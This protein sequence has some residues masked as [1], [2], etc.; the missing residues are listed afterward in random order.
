MTQRNSVPASSAPDTTP[1]GSLAQSPARVAVLADA[2]AA[3][4]LRDAWIAGPAQDEVRVR[5]AAC[6]VC[7]TDAVAR[8]MVPMPCVLGH[9]GA[10]VVEECGADVKDLRVG[11]RIML[12][13]PWCGEC[14]ACRAGKP[15]ACVRHFELA[16]GGRRK[17]GSRPIRIGDQP[18]AS[19]YFQQSSF[20]THVVAPA[21]SAVR[22]ESDVPLELAAAL[23]CGISTGAGAVVNTLRVGP[24]SSLVVFG[25][26][27][28][29]LAAVMAAGIAEAATIAVVDVN[30]RRLRLAE[31]LGASVVFD[32][33]DPDL[34]AQLSASLPAGASFVLDTSG[35]ASAWTN[36]LD[37]LGPDGTFAFVTL[38][39][40]LTEFQFK[41][42][43]L[44]VRAASMKAVL[45]GSSVARTFIPR[46]LQWHAAGRFPFDRLIT[47]YSFEDINRAF[48]DAAAGTAIK[49]VLTM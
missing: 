48:A 31:E 37:I 1:G 27:A 28:V 18:V 16:F 9:E 19:A 13:Y 38:P 41:P 36:A 34:R 39:Q 20:S 33:R 24:G 43:P 46:L 17:D 45:Q 4:E 21:R 14:V 6:G 15:H 12:T 2:G 7:H 47:T 40:P 23:G 49:P 29:G 5:I 8:H 42:L 32:A 26:G 44:F 10:G 3:F 25:A 35:A 22:V 30:P 11:D